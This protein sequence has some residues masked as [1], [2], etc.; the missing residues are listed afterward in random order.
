MGFFT[1]FSGAKVD[2]APDQK[3]IPAKEFSEIKKAAAIL[4]KT[5]KESLEFKKEV[6]KEAET[7][8][9]NAAKEGFEEGLLALNEKILIMDS[10][11]KAFESEMAKKILPIALKAA[12]KIL[13][14]ELK[15]HPDRIIDIVQQVLKPVT[16][17]HRVQIYVNKADLALLEQSKS[18]I[19]EQLHQA[20]VFSIQERSDIEPGGCIIE[21][22]AGIINAQLENQW[23]ALE[24]AF[25]KMH[26]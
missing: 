24:K 14:E 5:K 18:K 6:A 25:E 19:K 4:K 16:E 23:R 3:I 2:I 26:K 10:M 1:L 8:K 9:E 7:T 13:G 20:K 12:K 15:I 11:I 17:H 22:E 21:T